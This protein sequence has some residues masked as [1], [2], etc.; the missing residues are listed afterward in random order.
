MRGLFESLRQTIRVLLKA[1]GF[2][3]TAVLILG[4]GI[5]ANTAIFSLINAV[6]LKPLPYSHPERLVKVLLAYQNSSADAFDYL[7]Y[8]DVAAAQTGFDSIALVH[9]DF[10][11]L[12]GSGETQRLSIDF[13]S[14]S[15]FTLTGRPVILGRTFNAQ[16]DIPHGPLLAVISE[17]FWRNHFNAD[18]NVIGKSLTLSEQSFEI[19]GVVPAQMD[20]WG[21]PPTD[22]YLTVNSIVLF[23]YPIYQRTYHIFGCVGR[24]KE[25]VSIAKAQAELE[26]VQNGLIG[27]YPETDKG[28]GIRV[29]PLLDDV[30]EGY[31]GTVWLLGAAVAV[32]LLI[33][34]TNVATLL[35]VRGLERRRE[36]AIRVAIGATRSRLIAQLL[37]ETGLLAL[38]GGVAGLGLAF[39]SI[40][41]IK[42]LSPAEV[43]RFQEV[44]IDLTTLVF[45]IGIIVLVA[46][47][48]GVVP[49]L[50]FSRPK[51]GS[52]LKEEGGRSGTGGVQKYRAQTILVAAQ[53]A[54]ACI[55]LI[56]AGLLVRS[57]EA[58]QR[59]PL[60][61]NPHNIITAELS[62]TSSS[63]ET[64]GVKTRAFWDA[65]LAKVR[66]LPG[67]TGVAMDDRVP[68]YY[69]WE[70][71]WQ[72][73]VDG[74][75]DPGVGHR[76]VAN[77]HVISPN[78]FRTL[79]VPLLKG[80]DFNQEDRLEGRPVVIIDDTMADRYFPGEN[81]IGKVINVEA[82]SSEFR[83]RHWTIIGIVPHVRFRS[84]G[85]PENQFEVYF[86]Y[87]QWDFDGEV[88][89]LRCQGD[90]NAQIAA[91]RKAVQSIDP[92]VPVPNIK[93]LD[94]VI[95][96]K[97]VTRKLASTLVSLFSG[98]ALCLSAIGLYGVL[99]YSVSQRRRE[100]GVRIAL[101]AEWFKIL[102]LVTQ[103]GF[104]LI[105]IG[106]VAGTVVALVCAHFIEG[107]LYGVTAIDPIS[108]LIAVMVLCLAGCVACL[109]PA[110][111]A[112]RINP[113]KALRE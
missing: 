17:R 74:Q 76:P 21:P 38:L 112:V 48:S 1:P 63:Y 93:A 40:E 70:G 51:L 62:L 49:A 25:G 46:F 87:S 81:P 61:F 20:V 50:S 44:G 15:L 14:P 7:D 28:Y 79:E 97:L 65:V 27:R 18:P 34:A 67:V 60:G 32:L 109:L 36:L 52:V 88:L 80:R 24:L 41:I 26:V 23:S 92:D 54:L 3:I 35:F 16:E 2:T 13:V 8:L 72:F 6:L 77:W 22:V 103:Q 99:T 107:M 19:I 96:Q 73:T 100:I 64:D 30:V 45:V 104:K 95:A 82:E 33:A 102:Q 59:A 84:P 66:Q 69:D 58:A 101:G 53:V 110:L 108:M 71:D 47:I 83:P 90:P 5:G 4:F 55:L 94:D 86:P 10:L 29:K 85:T 113:V 75:P 57:F 37:L 56:G 42:K 39:G 89:L 111:R 91:V 9:G 31:S 43:Y 106:L 12:T 98:A 68:M 105:G 78:Y 11:D